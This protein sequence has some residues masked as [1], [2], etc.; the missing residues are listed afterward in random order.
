MS[1]EQV[2]KKGLSKAREI[3]DSRIL[4]ALE[5]TAFDLEAMRPF[6]IY[7]TNNLLDSIGCAIYQDGVLLKIF[8]PDQAADDPR[9][10]YSTYPVESRVI[11]DSE[12]ALWDVDDDA[13]NIFREWWGSDELVNKLLQPSFDV[14]TQVDGFAL[15]YVA[16]MPYARIIDKKYGE[17]VLKEEQAGIIFKSHIRSYGSN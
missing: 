13:V 7:W 15:Y 2:I 14:S 11:E 3:I 10:G 6:H 8:T 12:V 17:V 16:A 4:R 9:S 5:A 1:N